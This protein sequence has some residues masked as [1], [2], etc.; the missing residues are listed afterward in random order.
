MSKEL[1][2]A[3][4]ILEKE[5]NIPRETLFEALEN[6]PV[7]VSSFEEPHAQS[8]AVN[9]S[10]II[11]ER[12]NLH[13]LFIRPSSGPPRFFTCSRTN[14]YT[15]IIRLLHIYRSLFLS[16]PMRRLNNCYHLHLAVFTVLC[17]YTRA[18]NV[19]P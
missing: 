12:I 2:D 18:R 17:Y 13:L 7:T 14:F 10:A 6:S 19:S 4:D 5:K 15:I 11:I 1:M 16:G 8:T 3:L 9:A